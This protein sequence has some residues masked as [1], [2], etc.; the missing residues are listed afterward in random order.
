MFAIIA[1]VVGF[2]IA[3]Y[4]LRA[5]LSDVADIKANN[6]PRANNK[7]DDDTEPNERERSMVMGRSRERVYEADLVK[8]TNSEPKQDHIQYLDQPLIRLMLERVEKEQAEKAKR[9]KSILERLFGRE[10]HSQHRNVDQTSK[11]V[12]LHKSR[13]RE[14]YLERER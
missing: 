5:Q 10:E 3:F 11:S 9:S 14:R 6:K 4:A 13:E 7:P 2:M 1:L 8:R 12:D